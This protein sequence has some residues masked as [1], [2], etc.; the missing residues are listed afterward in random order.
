MKD[1]E[2]LLRDEDLVRIANK[3]AQGFSRV[4]SK[5]EIRTC[6]MSAMWKAKNKFDKKKNIKFSTYLYNMVNYECS[7]QKKEIL[8]NRYENKFYDHY[9]DVH[10]Y[11]SG[12]RH[13]ERIS[14][15]KKIDLADEIESCPDPELI[16]DKFYYNLSLS[17]IAKKRGVSKEAIRFKIK[18][19]LNSLKRKLS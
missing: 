13:N 6:I 11:R 12:I 3:A 19:T 16:F 10:S 17:E 8:K 7:K 5:D 9:L 1:V 18:K 15:I 4:L 14:E 2:Q